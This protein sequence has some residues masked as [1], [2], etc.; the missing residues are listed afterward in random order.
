MLGDRGVVLAA[1]EALVHERAVLLEAADRAVEVEA[2]KA[3]RGPGAEMGK[4]EEPGELGGR[5]RGLAVEPLT[6]AAFLAAA[7]S[8]SFVHYQIPGIS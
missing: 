5:D 3:A 8:F 1:D 6:F 7:R 4:A 2:A